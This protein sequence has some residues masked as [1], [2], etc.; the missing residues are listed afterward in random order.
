[1]IK[2]QKSNIYLSG[3]I[4][5]LEDDAIILFLRAKWELIEKHGSANINVINPIDTKPLF[6]IKQYWFFMITDIIA[7]LKCDAVYFLN[8]W[9]DSRGAKIEM[10]IALMFK[11]RILMQPHN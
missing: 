2:K 1:M 9:T 10:R 3:K 7:L 8:N 4:S 11:K 6:G 5:G